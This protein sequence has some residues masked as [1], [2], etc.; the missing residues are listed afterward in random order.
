MSSSTE[1]YRGS[2]E[3]RGSVPTT[4]NVI[5][6]PTWWNLGLYYGSGGVLILGLAIWWSPE[7]LILAWP[8]VSLGIVAAGYLG[9]GPGVFAKKSGRIAPAAR[10]LLAPYLLALW[11]RRLTEWRRG[12]TTT[13]S[14]PGC[15]WAVR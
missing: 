8:G 1:A 9:L 12:P 11:L 15:F 3:L 14:C 10:L 13:R 5:P 6:L 7:G 4:T 2:E